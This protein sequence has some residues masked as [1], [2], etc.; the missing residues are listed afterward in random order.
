MIKKKRHKV[1]RL[2]IYPNCNKV[3][4]IISW[5]LETFSVCALD[6]KDQKGSCLEWCYYRT[7]CIIT[8]R[9]KQ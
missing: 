2:Y 4:I 6:S 3:N 1:L 9:N 5:H 8:P 7:S